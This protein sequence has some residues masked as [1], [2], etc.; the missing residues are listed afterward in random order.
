MRRVG[1]YQRTA[2]KGF[3]LIEAVAAVAVVLIIGSAVTLSSLPV[4]NF[5]K[6]IQTR[7]ELLELHQGLMRYAVDF[8]AF[9]PTIDD[10]LA[11]RGGSANVLWRGPYVARTEEDYTRDAWNNPYRYRVGPASLSG[12]PVS[13][14][15][16]PGRN[17]TLET[18]ISSFQQLFWNLR[19][20]DLGLRPTIQGLH[21]DT[22]VLTRHS[23]RVVRGRVLEDSPVSAPVTYDTS[24]FRD[25]WNTPIQYRYCNPYGAVIYSYGQNRVDDSGGGTTLCAGPQPDQSDDWYLYITWERPVP[26]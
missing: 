13:A 8:G 22:M 15:V 12:T 4:V 19:G 17:G 9:P 11:P 16:A 25:G 18:E 10:L 20:D 1:T 7:T 5:Y 23:L 6:G 14:I 24:G 3:T 26:G 21:W 2:A